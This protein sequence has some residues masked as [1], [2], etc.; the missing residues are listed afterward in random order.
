MIRS[1]QC[2]HRHL[3]ASAREEVDALLGEVGK[4]VDV[5]VHLDVPGSSV[6]RPRPPNQDRLGVVGRDARRHPQLLQVAAVTYRLET[7]RP[8]LRSWSE[9]AVLGEETNGRGCRAQIPQLSQGVLSDN[10]LS[11]PWTSTASPR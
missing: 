10:E 9:L 5:H 3:A 6:Q 1:W 4:L 11:R 8:G 7:S 2:L